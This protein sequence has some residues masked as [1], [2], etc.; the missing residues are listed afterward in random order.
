[1]FTPSADVPINVPL[2]SVTVGGVARI[3]GAAKTAVVTAQRATR[4]ARR[5]PMNAKNDDWQIPRGT[6]RWHY[7]E[8]KGI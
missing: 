6:F 2:S 7:E 8:R 1:L 4:D 5:K 3:E